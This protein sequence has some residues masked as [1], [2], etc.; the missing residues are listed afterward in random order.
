MKGIPTKCIN[1]KVNSD[2]GQDALLLYKDLY[3]GKEVKFDL[4]TG[5][6]CC[7]KTGKDHHIST[8]SMTRTVCFPLVAEPRTT[9]RQREEESDFTE[10]EEEYEWVTSEEASDE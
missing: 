8:V 9:K 3:E 5:G 6:N 10:G 7:F 4:T 1:A 2:Y